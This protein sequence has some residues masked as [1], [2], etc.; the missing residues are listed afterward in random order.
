[1]KPVFCISL[2]ISM[3]FSCSLNTGK[4][5]I[6]Y[7]SFPEEKTLK[8]EVIPLDTALFR[9]PFR[10]TVRDSIAIVLDLHN[11]DH[12]LHAFSYPEWKH[13]VSFGK[14]GEGPEE[15]LSA[16]TFQVDALGSVWVLDANRMQLTRWRISTRERLAE[17][18]EEVNLDKSLIRVLDFYVTETGFLFPDYSGEY[19]FHRTNR[20]GKR[21]QSEG[22]IPTEKIA[23]D[24]FN[25]ALAQAWR[26]F[27]DCHPRHDLLAMATQL[28][29]VIEL[30]HLND[31]TRTVVRGPHDEP[32][33]RVI[34]GEGI[35]T[36]IMGFSD[37]QITDNHIYAVFHGRTFKEIQIAYQKGEKPESGGRYIYVF[38]LNGNPVR[39][40]TLDRA[41]YGIDVNEQAR[42]ILA[43]DVNSDEPIVQ[44]KF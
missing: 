27:M 29:E 32:E 28:G 15:L 23:K 11:A 35:P 10:I 13:I 24:A 1:M 17:R 34:E 41:I 43:T 20:Q 37:I 3:L 4:Q 12:Y 18:L 26:S 9:Y 38:D 19:R 14:R 8:S 5:Y 44:I 7:K 22:R 31:T 2:L 39:K 6:V 33:F 25:P 21:L 30:Y 40:Y 42:T 16:E 36:G